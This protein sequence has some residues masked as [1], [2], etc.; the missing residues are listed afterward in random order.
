MYLA[1]ALTRGENGVCVMSIINAT[2]KDQTVNLPYVDLESLE[3]G[4][5]SLNPT[6]STVATSDGRLTDLRNQLRFTI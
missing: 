4:E 1:S 6:L 5:S 2:E 3:E